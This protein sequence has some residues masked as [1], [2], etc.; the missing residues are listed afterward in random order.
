[1][2]PDFLYDALQQD[3]AEAPGNYL[4]VG[5]RVGIIA[6]DE[7][8]VVNDIALAGAPATATVTLSFF[9]PLP[10]DRFTLT[11]SD[12]L[13]DPA[14][15]NLDGESNADEPNGAPDFPSGDGIPGG[16][17]VA[18]FTVDSRPEIGTFV[19]QQI[20]IDIN[21]DFTFDPAASSIGGDATNVD[22]SFSL[23]LANADGSVAPGGFNVSDLAFAGQFVATGNLNPPERLFDQLAAYGF[24]AELG[25]FRWIV[26][27]NSDGVVTIGT[28]IFTVQPDLDFIGFDDEGA[29]PIA[30][31]FDGDA[32]NGDE[33]GLYYAGQW[34]LDTNRNFII[35]PG[36]VI[37]NGLLGHPVVGDFDGDGGDDL[38]VFNNNQLFFDFSNDGFF[39]VDD[40]F[41]FGF[42]G[43]LDRPIAADFNQDGIDDI[44]LFIPGNSAGLFREQ[45]E[46][47]ILV[48]DTA[49]ANVGTADALDTP[50]EIAPF[51]N[52]IFAQFGDERALPIV[53]N[54]D[55]PV[56]AIT[57]IDAPEE[58]GA[59]AD[60]TTPTA[61]FAAFASS[62]G[63]TGSSAS[64]YNGDQTVNAAD[65]VLLRDSL[66]STGSGD[67][68]VALASV[69]EPASSVPE[70]EP[71]ADVAVESASSAL[72]FVSFAT[73]STT[74]E[75]DESPASNVTDGSTSDENR[76]QLL[77]STAAAF[78]I[79]DEELAELT[80]FDDD[81][82][83][84][85]EPSLDEFFAQLA[86]SGVA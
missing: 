27:T 7:V 41:I 38:A 24:S 40:T 21:G 34:G 6:I 70:T 66:N 54:F 20:N 47:R 4:L 17:F 10:D 59:T 61:E 78:A 63:G 48:S 81:T 56:A 42:P 14:G 72:S 57:E 80:T 32:T 8:V 2:A 68:E 83:D 84:S 3:V 65:F 11:I 49:L 76:L 44:G 5:D 85:D 13:V 19:A 29:L 58:E 9:E 26:D 50:F 75:I 86:T 36:E 62:F 45:G 33:I 37:T 35:D 31:N 69:Q 46:W 1:M 16:D 67:S 25:T 79:T 74:S 64:D 43:V 18:R 60:D 77:D 53:G 22:L 82:S 39:G 12:N 71:E 23:G 55:P 15:N 51:G 28:D 73:A 52:D 30:G